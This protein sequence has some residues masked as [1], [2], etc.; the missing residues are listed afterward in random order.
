MYNA[1]ERY[2]L[3]S[4]FVLEV[5]QLAAREG[6]AYEEAINKRLAELEAEALPEDDHDTEVLPEPQ[7]DPSLY[8]KALKERSII[9]TSAMY[10]NHANEVPRVCPCDRLCYCRIHGACRGKK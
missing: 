1:N 4:D 7:G 10:C 6:L 3:I 2:K 9:S 8:I 5:D